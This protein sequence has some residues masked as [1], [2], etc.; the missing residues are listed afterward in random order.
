[1]HLATPRQQ[2]DDRTTKQPV[3][4]SGIS[5]P[6]VLLLGYSIPF[7]SLP[8]QQ[9]AVASECDTCTVKYRRFA[10]SLLCTT[11]GYVLL[12]MHWKGQDK[13]K[14]V[15]VMIELVI[16]E[17]DGGKIQSSA[18]LSS[19]PTKVMASANRCRMNCCC[20]HASAS[21]PFD[22]PLPIRDAG[23]KSPASSPAQAGHAQH[24][25]TCTALRSA[26]HPDDTSH[27]KPSLPAGGP[28][29]PPL[30]EY[31]ASTRQPRT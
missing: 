10:L 18:Q 24:P 30:A 22:A 21:G 3:S 5:S 13:R 6:A 2:Q 16:T 1:M 11:V 28:R 14:P 31:T 17:G 19:S 8:Y 29:Q 26:K 27:R 12:S 23:V 9:G 15:T 20:T 7:K 4:A 25:T